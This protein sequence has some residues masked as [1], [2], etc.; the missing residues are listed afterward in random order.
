MDPLV[1]LILVPLAILLIFAVALGWRHPRQGSQIVGGS[2]SE[3]SDENA[4][5]KRRRTGG[6]RGGPR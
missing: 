5:L 4:K 2:V 1:G 6:R 3:E